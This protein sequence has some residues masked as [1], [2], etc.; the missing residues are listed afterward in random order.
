MAYDNVW[1]WEG[2]TRKSSDTTARSLTEPI[3][4][5][6]FDDVI[7]T[8]KTVILSECT[9]KL[10]EEMAKIGITATVTKIEPEAWIETQLYDSRQY[11]D[12]T[13]DYWHHWLHMKAKV[14]F[15][16]DKPLSESPIAPIVLAGLVTVLKYLILV[17]A[18][19]AVIYGIAKVFIESFFTSYEEVLIYDEE[20]NLIEHHKKRTPEWSQGIWIIAAI[21]LVLFFI[22]V[23]GR[24]K[25]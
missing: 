4:R 13:I 6:P 15:T 11:R 3:D 10:E 25:R 20:G 21:A 9:Q 19:G 22:F 18:A 24:H 7:R 12:Y 2:K 17:I 23:I 1:S 16:T 14:Y 8:A 5:F